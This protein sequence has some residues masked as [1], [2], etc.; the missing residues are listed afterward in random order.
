MGRSVWTLSTCGLAESESGLLTKLKRKTSEKV[1]IPRYRSL[2]EGLGLPLG[3]TSHFLGHCPFQPSTH[4]RNPHRAVLLIHPDPWDQR[5]L[6]DPSLSPIAAKLCIISPT[7]PSHSFSK[8]LSTFLPSEFLLCLSLR[9]WELGVSKLL[10]NCK[11]SLQAGVMPG[12][13]L[14]ELPSPFRAFW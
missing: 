2:L 12:A 5:P 10:P 13:R 8:G 11:L 4:T 3:L 9:D 6:Q 7:F 1:K 14:P